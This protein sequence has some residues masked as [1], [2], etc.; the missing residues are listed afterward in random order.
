MPRIVKFFKKIRK[1]HKGQSIAM[2]VADPLASLIAAALKPENETKSS[3]SGLLV[4]NNCGALEV[5][6][7]TDP[8]AI[9]LDWLLAK[10]PAQAD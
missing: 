1:K 6:N 4:V 10:V 9:D 7:L 2:V 5:L 8:D 3:D